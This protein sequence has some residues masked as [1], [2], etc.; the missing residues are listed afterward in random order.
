[1]SGSYSNVVLLGMPLIL[2]SLGPEARVPLF[3]VVS[4]HAAVMFL[5]TTFCAETGKGTAR[6]LST[7]PLQTLRVLLRNTI[8]IGLLLGLAVN[9]SGLSLP[10]TIDKMASYLGGAALP[11]AVFSM[12]ASISRYKLTGDVAKIAAAIAVKNLAHPLLVWWVAAR[13]VGLPETWTAVAVIFA[14]CP[15]GINTYLF[16]N[17]YRAIVPSTATVIV[18]STALSIVILSFVLWHVV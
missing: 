11:C 17:R 10:Q 3:I 13:V 9:L 15:A 6:N 4:T 16:A 18:I 12:G 8:V 14:A 5:L 1:M 2:A 7:L